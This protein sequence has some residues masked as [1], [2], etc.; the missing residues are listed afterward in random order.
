M[1]MSMYV[2]GIKPPDAKWNKMKKIYDACQEADMDVP[3]A[4]M[5]YFDGE[6]PDDKGVLLDESRLGKA[7][8]EYCVEGCSGFEVELSKLPKDVKILRFYNSW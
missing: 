6:D 7:V 8:S 2:V 3:D 4:V 5:D 1:G